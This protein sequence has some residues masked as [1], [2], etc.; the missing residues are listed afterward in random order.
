MKADAEHIF[1]LSDVG[2]DDVGCAG[3][4][5][6]N[7][8]E[9]TKA[10]VAVP[11]GFIVSAD[12]YF[13]FIDSANLRP[14]IYRLT[15]DL[16][17]NDSSRL[18]EVAGVL[19]AAICSAPVP[20]ELVRQIHG[21]YQRLGSGP[22]AVRSSATA[23]DIAEASFAGQQSTFLNV[24]GAENVVV[25][26]RDCW[27]SLYEARALFYRH[28]AGF[29]HLGVGIAVV[30]QRMI[31]SQRAGVMFTVEPVAGDLSRIC[32]EAI[33]G[34]GEALVG[35][36]VT[37]DT[38]V[39]D[40]V[41]LKI[42]EKKVEPQERQLVRNRGAHGPEDEANAWAKVPARQRRQ[43]KLSDDDITALAKQGRQIETHY[44]FPQDIEWAQEDG[45]FY[46]LQARPVTTAVE[47]VEAR[48]EA[49][50]ETARLILTGSAASPG[51]EAG[52]V[53]IVL[54]PDQLDKVQPG[55]VLVAE[56]T[57]PDYVPAMKRAAAI[58]TDRGGRTAHAAIVSR[59]LGIPCIVGAEKATTTLKDGQVITVD[60]A[61]GKVY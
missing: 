28:E 53:R 6:A 23:E 31:Q 16:D 38:Y 13:S 52:T 46:V 50:W 4:K 7:L 32:I 37:P 49:A 58:V 42:L 44:S 41:N 34:L 21:D 47:K 22:V 3:G 59:E 19:K 20:P 15:T 51:V 45:R 27:A 57:P 17:Y 39:V 26:V 56:M 24:E 8:G 10:G 33:Y 2:K 9:L 43:Q 48:E 54:S 5:G 61:K 14:A 55:D 12:A 11:P 30:V 29:D 25:A 18:Q 36:H 60:G 1:W 35:G 40:K